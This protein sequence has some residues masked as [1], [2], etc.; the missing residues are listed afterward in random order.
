M[1]LTPE[2]QELNELDAKYHNH[3]PRGTNCRLCGVGHAPIWPSAACAKC[4]VFY[5]DH[6]DFVTDHAFVPLPEEDR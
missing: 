6:I 2:E 1:T 4:D 5:G 3:L